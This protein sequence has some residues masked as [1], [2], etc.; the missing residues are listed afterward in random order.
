[1]IAIISSLKDKAS[2]NIKESLLNNFQFKESKEKFGGNLV[3][4]YEIDG[5]EM[6][7]YTVNSELIYTENIDKK[8]NADIFIFISKH[9]ASEERKALTVHPIG[10]FGKAEF[11]GKEKMLCFSPSFLLKN[12]YMELNKNSEEIDYEATMEATHHGPFLEKPVLFLEVGS[13]EEQWED[14]NAAKASAVSLINAIKNENKE[15]ENEKKWEST[16][17]IGGSH[18]NYVS[19]KAMLKTNFAVGHICAKYNLQNLDILLIKQAME[20]VLPKPKFVLLDW[21]GLGKEKRKLLELLE[22][23]NIAYQRSDKLFE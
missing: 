10:N 18:Y 1:M 12:I 6:N 15:Y 2:I 4:N 22:S 5:K 17:V 14:K 23:N 9:R 19:N 3:Y 16:F 8:I 13:A 20:K 11:G 21:K 7:L